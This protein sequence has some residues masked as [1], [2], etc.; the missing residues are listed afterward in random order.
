M[1]L[2]ERYAYPRH[3]EDKLDF[4]EEHETELSRVDNIYGLSHLINDCANLPFKEYYYVLTLAILLSDPTNQINELG[5]VLDDISLN[6]VFYDDLGNLRPSGLTNHNDTTSIWYQVDNLYDQRDSGDNDGGV[7]QR[8]S[9]LS[10]DEVIEQVA[11]KFKNSSSEAQKAIRSYFDTRQMDELLPNVA[12]L[13]NAQE[14][15]DKALLKRAHDSVFTNGKFYD[16]FYSRVFN[17]A[18]DDDEQNTR[19]KG[20][21][22]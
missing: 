7:D 3:D 14:P 5:Y 4:V 13:L 21:R 12:D 22:K 19:S 15:Y 16:A 11:S 18:V 1:Q 6:N 8:V 20:K 2:Q 17:K 10:D 9:K